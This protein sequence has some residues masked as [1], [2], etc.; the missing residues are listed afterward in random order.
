MEG[1]TVAD[2]VGGALREYTGGQK[3]ERKSAVVVDNR[4]SRICTALV[5]NH[6]VRILCEHVRNLTLTFVAPVGADNCF[7]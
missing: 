5:A 6:N 4:V 7:D 2:D 1:N 3:V